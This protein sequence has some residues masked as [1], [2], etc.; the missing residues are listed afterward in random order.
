MPPGPAP[1]L[2]IEPVLPALLA[3][4]GASGAAVLTAP[5]G[6]GKSTRVPLAL[7]ASGLVPENRQIVLLQPRRLAARA[8]ARRLAESLGEEVGQTIG[9]QVRFERRESSRTRVRVVTEGILQAAL[10][11]DPLLS[12]VGAV[13]LDEF[14]ERSAEADLALACLREV[15][16]ARPEL[17]LVVMSAT[18]EAEPI[19]R[20]LGDCPWV[21]CPVLAHPLAIDYL[22]QPEGRPLP[23]AV[24]AGLRHLG[25][26]EGDVLVFLPGAGEI[27]ACQEA[28][29]AAEL[30]GGPELAP[31]H[32]SLSAAEQDRIV[33]PRPA[34]APRRV[35]LSTNLAETSLT[36]PG[37]RAVVD[38]GLVK[39]PSADPALGLDRLVR[40][41][42][43]RASADQRAGRAA[44]LGPGRA[45]RLWSRAEQAALAARETPALLRLDLAGPLLS[46]LSFHPGDPAEL[47]FLDPPPEAA[48]AAALELLRALGAL[49]ARGFGLTPLGRRLA[50]LPLHPRLGAMLLEAA[51][52]GLVREAA[53]LAAL[54]GEREVL[55][56]P[57]GRIA[58][59]PSCDSDLTFRAEL[60]EEFAAA[61]QQPRAA[62]RLGLEAG[63]ARDAL[64]A[65]DQLIGLLERAAPGAAP[66]PGRLARLLLRAFPDRVCRRR[67]PGAPEARM[68]GGRGV[69]LAEE[70]GVREAPLFLALSADAG[71]RGTRSVS[72]VRLAA[73][74]A[75]AELEA[76]FPEA[77]GER[78]EA[79][80]DPERE[81]VVGVAVR[82]FRDLPL[83]EREGAAL[84]PEAAAEA[85]RAA[86]GPRFAELFQ[87]SARGAQL[88]ARLRLAA[89]HLGEQ[90]WPAADEVALRALLDQA[91]LGRRS[92]AEL[93]RLDWAELIRARLGGAGRRALDA[94]LPERLGV[95]SGRKLPVDYAPALVEGGAPVLAVRLQEMFGA[96]DSP[97]VAHGR[98]P[99]VLHLLGP[100]GR[101]VQVTADLA[102]FWRAGYPQVR[103]E[104]RGRYPR[105][106]WPEDPWRA[107]PTARAKPQKRC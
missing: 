7:L 42:V 76:V 15:R 67:A 95:P 81:S 18:L 13:L 99:V 1:P 74:L 84:E 55:T 75:P 43:S 32:G 49:P 36:V 72:L 100:H 101:P 51:E 94:A 102:S 86:A 73:A 19:Q 4:L 47:A 91:C 14:H 12:E 35:V 3:A 87:P 38:T 96:T 41:R 66:G 68:V 97:R 31:L 9:H 34:G 17:L 106:P 88:I 61:G 22:P 85:L 69:R 58:P 11:E 33:R 98:L 21:D 16:A 92:F 71:K 52:A 59:T 20:F 107:Q 78:I 37:V 24:R 50:R 28:L 93:R 63:A 30:P 64:R 83:E 90:A 82:R 25:D 104:L 5:P 10:A 2:P 57:F 103:R 27:R 23:E 48:R 40:G 60:V 46:A 77:L 44:R 45:V 80:F 56:A 6:A 79:R 39:R 8:V 26:L 29:A 65:R 70:S 54:L 89:R 62:A 105:H 53:L